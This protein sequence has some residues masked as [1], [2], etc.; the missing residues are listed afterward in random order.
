MLP[1]SACVRAFSPQVL[2][3]L[4]P[5]TG[6]LG[7]PDV[8]TL[9]FTV[10]FDP[11]RLAVDSRL[12]SLMT[13]AVDALGKLFSHGFWAQ[14]IDLE[15]VM[16]PRSSIDEDDDD[17]PVKMTG[18]SI[19]LVPL[20]PITA[21]DSVSNE[22]TLAPEDKS[23]SGV[24]DRDEQEDEYDAAASVING[25]I[26]GAPG[27]YRNI[28]RIIVDKICQAF[29]LG[30]ETDVQ[31]QLQIIKVARCVPAILMHDH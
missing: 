24:T 22:P 11:L 4:L 20:P 30:E 12:P 2:F 5:H 9:Q 23:L 27:T 28:A 16:R 13:I 25:P 29:H 7:T 1:K 10:L 18:D 15:S 3:H 14:M 21:P 17:V 6:V 19:E 8:G 26:T 31:L